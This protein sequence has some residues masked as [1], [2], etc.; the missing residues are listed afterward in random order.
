MDSIKSQDYYWGRV[1]SNIDW[2]ENNYEISPYI[3]E[4]YN[5]FSSFVISAFGIYGIYLMMSASSRD[6]QLFEHIKI[7]KK[8]NIRT[9]LIL[10]YTSLFLVGVGSAFYHATLLY[11]NQLFDEFPML[12]TAATFIYSML[13]IDPVDKEKDP[14]WYIFMRKYL[15]IGL[16]SY[17]IAVAITISIIRD[18]PTILQVAFGFLICSNVV[19][20]HFY[21]RK[22]KI[23]LSESNP[24]KFLLFCC[25]SMLSAYFSWLIERKL[26]SNGNVIPGI[27]LHSVWHALTGLA[28]FYFVQ[29]Y[30]SACLEKHGYKTQINWNYGVASVRGFIKSSM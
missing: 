4:F 21:A 15:P 1:T 9:Q 17:V 27:Q 7:L 28:G 24:K 8:L 5:T 2:C 12:L 3:C 26:C 20:S 29:F 30:L 23:P 18:C 22:I 25:I 14:K 6:Q 16:S 13:T 10:S 11:E 19:L